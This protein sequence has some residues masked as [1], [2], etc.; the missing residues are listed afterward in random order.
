M[1]DFT[2]IIIALVALIFSGINT[3]WLLLK[4]LVRVR[5]ISDDRSCIKFLDS[6]RLGFEIRNL[7]YIP[8]SLSNIR[9]ALHRSGKKGVIHTQYTIDGSV[10]LPRRLE[11]RTSVKVQTIFSVSEQ[12]KN[13]Y[14]LENQDYIYVFIYTS[15]GRFHRRKI[16]AIREEGP[17]VQIE[18]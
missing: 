2:P 12:E 9:L 11:P 5:I 16:K 14:L 15:C 8:V 18:T 1:Q 7:S 17:V 3:A 13:S 10:T 6:I 4:D